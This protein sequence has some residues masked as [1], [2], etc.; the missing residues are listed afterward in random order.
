MLKKIY[1]IEDSYL[2]KLQETG[3][4][5]NL[6]SIMKM[7]NNE[8]YTHSA[9]IAELLNPKGSHGYNNRFLQLF[10]ETVGYH[11][12]STTTCRVS[13]EHYAGVIDIE[14]YSSRTFVDIVLR[15]G[16]NQE[17]LIENKIWAVDQ[18]L[19]LERT[20]KA[21][22]AFDVKVLYL[23][24]FGKEYL[25]NSSLEY[26]CISYQEHISEWLNRCISESAPTPIVSNSIKVYKN[27]VDKITNQ[28]IYFQMSKHIKEEIL[29]NKENF[30][31]A[32]L[33][34]SNYVEMI[35]N[36]GSKFWESFRK[37][38][39]M[40]L[41]GDINCLGKHC[42]YEI[43]EQKTYGDTLYIQIKF[44]DFDGLTVLDDKEINDFV[45]SLRT[46]FHGEPKHSNKDWNIWFYANE[47][48]ALY[49]TFISELSV[50]DKFDLLTTGDFNGHIKEA[51]T[52]F[53][54]IIK[55]LEQSSVATQKE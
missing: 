32:Q 50:E 12:F 7:E 8:R 34:H 3:E 14:D 21:S 6:I 10:L 11:D 30:K 43:S 47:G 27:V 9:I 15:N 42:I 29:E 16:C 46:E 33:I 28:N 36:I 2:S 38:L 24:P 35:S 13:V 19:Q 1:Q 4:G 17:I 39:S 49:N 55:R 20:R 23:T 31:T 40:P 51:A 18:P 22:T 26:D 53:R 41:G 44:V 5:F 54:A 45:E 52:K 25:Q 48:N 37:E